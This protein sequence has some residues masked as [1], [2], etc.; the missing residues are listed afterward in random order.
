MNIRQVSARAVSITDRFACRSS[1]FHH[2][3]TV[4]HFETWRGKLIHYGLGNAYFSDTLNIH[5]LE[6]SRSHAI[7]IGERE[8]SIRPYVKLRPSEDCFAEKRNPQIL[9]LGKYR[10]F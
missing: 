2:S 7:H 6:D 3:H 4:G 9:C 5:Q 1:Y 10:K 8:I